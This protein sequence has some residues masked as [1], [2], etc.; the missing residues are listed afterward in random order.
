ME[1]FLNLL[2]EPSTYAGLSG[3]A[4]AMGISVEGWEAISATLAAL[5]GTIAVFTKEKQSD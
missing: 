3:I 5:F 4:L 2:K 1:D